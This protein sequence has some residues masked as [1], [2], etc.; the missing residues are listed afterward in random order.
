VLKRMY[1]DNTFSQMRSKP[2]QL[3]YI[4]ANAMDTNLLQPSRRQVV[5]I[6]PPRERPSHKFVNVQRSVAFDYPSSNDPL[7]QDITWLLFRPRRRTQL[8]RGQAADSLS[9]NRRTKSF[10]E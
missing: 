2:K 9:G 4:G 3:T 6:N 1:P 8:C 5:P 10:V 7:A